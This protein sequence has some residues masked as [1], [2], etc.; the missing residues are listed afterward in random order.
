MNAGV[1]LGAIVVFNEPGFGHDS[2]RSAEQSCFP[3]SAN[4]TL[5]LNK[6]TLTLIL[7][8]ALTLTLTLTLIYP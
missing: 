8:L 6:L 5:T 2:S 4:A 1:S 7:A 3:Y